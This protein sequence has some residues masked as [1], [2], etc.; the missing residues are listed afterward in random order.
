ML[1]GTGPALNCR[2]FSHALHALL[3][4]DLPTASGIH[5]HID[6]VNK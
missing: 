1:R 3:V 2:P 4:F 6:L 5:R